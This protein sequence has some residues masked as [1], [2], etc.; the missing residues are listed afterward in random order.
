[1]SNH[2]DYRLEIWNGKEYIRTYAYSDG[3]RDEHNDVI[4]ALLRSDDG[5]LADPKLMAYRIVLVE[6][7]RTMKPKRKDMNWGSFTSRR[8]NDDGIDEKQQAQVAADHYLRLRQRASYQDQLV[9]VPVY[10]VKKSG[11]GTAANFRADLARLLTKQVPMT[12][13]TFWAKNAHQ[14]RLILE[15]RLEA[16]GFRFIEVDLE[17]YA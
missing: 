15:D 11:R 2:T 17:D 10:P 14:T 1:M 16:A 3:S 9:E 12:G 8:R 7:K 13:G 4:R 6:K 5:L